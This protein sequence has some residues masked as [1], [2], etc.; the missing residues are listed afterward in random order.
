M[1]IFIE[2]KKFLIYSLRQSIRENEISNENKNNY[3]GIYSMYI[4]Y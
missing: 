3:L 4:V 2:K 1:Y